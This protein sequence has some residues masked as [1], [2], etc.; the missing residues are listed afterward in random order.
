[1][2]IP[3][4]MPVTTIVPITIPVP[5]CTTV[6]ATNVNDAKELK[7]KELKDGPKVKYHPVHITSD[8]KGPN[9][10]RSGIWGN[11]F[12][13]KDKSDVERKLVI[14]Q[15]KYLMYSLCVMP[16]G[17]KFRPTKFLSMIKTTF[18][19]TYPKCHCH[20]KSCHGDVLVELANE[21]VDASV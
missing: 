10:T 11:P 3:I 17:H 16:D 18:A 12:V 13:M 1:M 5:D 2:S 6:S 4:L 20:P 8:L 21:S 7:V 15:H 9:I 14:G 19:K